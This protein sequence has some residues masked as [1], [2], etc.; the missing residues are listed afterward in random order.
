[1]IFY[2][3]GIRFYYHSEYE[4]NKTTTTDLDG[5]DHPF[6]F[7]VGN[8]N[9]DPFYRFRDWYIGARYKSMKEEVLNANQHKL[10]MADY[11]NMLPLVNWKWKAYKNEIKVSLFYKCW[12]KIY[13]LKNDGIIQS[14]HVLA[15]MY[16]TFSQ[17]KCRILPKLSKTI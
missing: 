1:M 11:L 3:N 17:F 15:V 8:F 5:I 12:E 14:N 4:N 13:G 7:D 6:A 2:E 9:V 10:S 16:Y